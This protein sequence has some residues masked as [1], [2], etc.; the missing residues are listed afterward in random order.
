MVVGRNVPPNPAG[1]KNAW[2]YVDK[3]G[4]S[5]WLSTPYEVLFAKQ[6]DANPDVAYWAQSSPETVM[7]T[8]VRHGGTPKVFT[9]DFII[10]GTDGRVQVVEIKNIGAYKQVTWRVPEKLREAEEFFNSKGV[11]FSIFVEDQLGRV[12]A[13]KARPEDFLPDA[14]GRSGVVNG[15][16]VDSE[17]GSKRGRFDPEAARGE[18][19]KRLR[20]AGGAWDLNELGYL[21]GR[22]PLTQEEYDEVLASERWPAWSGRMERGRIG[23]PDRRNA[24]ITP[25][26]RKSIIAAGVGGVDP[27]EG[28]Y[29]RNYT[30]A[31]PLRPEQG[32]YD[33]RW[34]P[35]QAYAEF[36]ERQRR[37][38]APSI[39]TDAVRTYP[40]M[41]QRSPAI[42][43]EWGKQV[44]DGQHGMSVDPLNGTFGVPGRYAVSIYPDIG[45]EFKGKFDQIHPDRLAMFMAEAE[46][47]LREVP[48]SRVGVWYDS[49]EDTTYLDLSVGVDSLKRA[50]ALGERMSQK[51][52]FDS[53][54][55]QDI[56]L[57]YAGYA[58]G[59]VPPPPARQEQND[60]ISAFARAA[61]R[62][63]PRGAAV[64]GAAALR[65]AG[66]VD[67]TAAAAVGGRAGGLAG[68][69][70]GAA[71]P[72]PGRP[73]GPGGPGLGGLEPGGVGAEGA[74][75]VDG[76]PFGS[77]PPPVPYSGGPG[78]GDGAAAAYPGRGAAGGPA[79]EAAPPGGAPGAPG[80]LT[81][82]SG[83]AQPGAQGALGGAAGFAYTP[84]EEN[85]DGEEPTFE[86]RLLR[87]G[88][89]AVAGGL[90]T[91]KTRGLLKGAPGALTR[92]P[93][94]ISAIPLAA[95]TSLAAN[96]T[97]GMARSLERVAGVA[98]E[99]RPI[100]AMVDLAGMVRS[101]PGAVRGGGRAFKSGPTEANPGMTGALTPDDLLASKN[102][103]AQVATGG[104]RANAATDQFWRDLNEAGARAQA[105]RRGLSKADA[106]AYATRAGD[107]ATFT[108]SNSVV[109]K[110]LTE[111]KQTVRDPNASVF[112]RSVAGAITSM[113]PYV[114]MPER[115]LRATIG[116][117][118]PVESATGMV[119]A[120]MKGDRAAAREMRGRTIAGLAATTALTYHYFQ[121]GITG[122]RPEDANEARRREAR[123]E[124][125]NTVQ[126]P[127]GR[128]PSR[129]L[130]SLGMQANAIATTLDSARRAKEEG[131]D[132]GAVIEEGFNGAARWMLDASYLSDL[133][134]FGADVQGPE[135]AAGAL[136]NVAAGIPS[137]ITGPVTGAIGAADEY[138]REAEGFPEQVMMRTG[139]RSQLPARIDPTTG[140][141]QRRRGP[142][143]TGTGAPGA[144]RRPRRG[145]NWPACG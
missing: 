56:G 76:A 117:L 95:P 42:Y 10:V 17:E 3:N 22:H 36:N 11:G 79:G 28:G 68:G 12:A 20:E 16:F 77:Y 144:A 65:G 143:G 57:R 33:P 27:A 105:G 129:F 140:E 137:R 118:I 96:L 119:R 45:L 88:T 82:R 104:V 128:V 135:G 127:A 84:E 87:G 103:A 51:A 19:A 66:G 30:A 99:G 109:A 89:L 113:A 116:A 93:E 25:D 43:E 138:E 106:D 47:I 124:Q 1:K 122:D 53:V 101:L 32:G 26:Q 92:V 39:A 50:K 141:A 38:G 74:A 55:K 142:A 72:G 111:M 2:E 15:F 73:A 60:A 29:G 133:S 5:Q 63:Q 64:P 86:E 31:Y 130:G 107:F 123:G 121:G 21:S 24:L 100:D 145:R 102:R 69:V 75:G 70:P 54:A 71:A 23:R 40:L 44:A 136:R 81:D 97:G 134:E 90:G 94:L 52:I 6:L 139:L 112:D 7:E 18:L 126:T 46:P 108:G 4:R 59:E 120:Y 37:K 80:G 35:H 78:A 91:G 110:K 14:N 48:G 49:S 41:R 58:L 115:L 85:E 114:M 62:S 83:L 67:G 125:W 8:T 9:P 61:A 132:P 98:A 34:T 13:G 131:G